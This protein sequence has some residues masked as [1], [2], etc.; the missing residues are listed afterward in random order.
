MREP[1]TVLFV[2]QKCRSR[3]N[4]LAVPWL[5]GFTFHYRSR[6]H[7]REQVTSLNS[8]GYSLGNDFTVRRK[9]A[10]AGGITW[11]SFE[12]QED[13]ACSGLCLPASCS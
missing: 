1:G 4:Y 7:M 9:A 11:K 3:N 13:E 12:S 6:R 2:P 8:L 10:V 5:T